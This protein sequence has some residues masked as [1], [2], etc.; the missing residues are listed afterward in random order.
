MALTL[1]N[2]V[3]L[4]GLWGDPRLNPKRNSAWVSLITEKS[5][6]QAIHAAMAGVAGEHTH[7]CATYGQARSVLRDS[8]NAEGR[9]VLDSQSFADATIRI[10]PSTSP[11]WLPSLAFVVFAEESVEY[12]TAASVA[13]DLTCTTGGP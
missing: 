8:L 2:L 5:V 9:M 13:F 6:H 11:I 4:Y 7:G 12:Q 1:P 3:E 10:S